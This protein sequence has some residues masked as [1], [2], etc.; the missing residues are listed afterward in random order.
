[1]RELSNGCGI[2]FSEQRASIDHGDCHASKSAAAG[3]AVVQG[4]VVV[5]GEQHGLRIVEDVDAPARRFRQLVLLQVGEQ[6]QAP[7]HSSNLP[8]LLLLQVPQ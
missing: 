4:G 1:V 8:P 6:A 5:A 3:V 2:F 7:G